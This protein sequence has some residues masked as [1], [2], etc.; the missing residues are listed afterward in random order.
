V[1]DKNIEEKELKTCEMKPNEKRK[2]VWP[3][4]LYLEGNDQFRG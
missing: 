2:D 1:R 3:A 4:D